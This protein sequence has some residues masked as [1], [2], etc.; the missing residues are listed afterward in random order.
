M[1][2]EIGMIEPEM[3][4]G[5]VI[6]TGIDMVRLADFEKSL[7]QGGETF[8]QRLFH[9]TEAAGASLQRLAGV[10]AAKEAAYKALDLPKGD[11]HALEIQHD[12][13]GKPSII[14]SPY[15]DKDG[16]LSCDVSISHS[17]D[18]AVA[19]VVALWRKHGA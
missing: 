1:E 12:N 6:R 17:G 4:Y 5:I 9:P 19:N 3:R 7:K 2:G 11:W 18:Y 15:V 13:E 8:L 14:L 16:L 10:F